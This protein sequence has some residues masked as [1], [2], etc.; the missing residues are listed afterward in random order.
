MGLLHTNIDTVTSKS[1]AS[2]GTPADNKT[3]MPLTVKDI[4]PLKGIVPQDRE[5]KIAVKVAKAQKEAEAARAKEAKAKQAEEA[6]AKEAEASKAKQAEAAKADKDARIKALEEQLKA[7]QAQAPSTTE[8][9][10]EF[11]SNAST[12]DSV[13]SD[14]GSDAEEVVYVQPK[15]TAAG[16]V[17]MVPKKAS[18]VTRISPITGKVLSATTGNT[19]VKYASPADKRLDE[20]RDRLEIIKS[21]MFKLLADPVDRRASMVLS[22]MLDL[23]KDTRLFKTNG[24]FNSQFLSNLIDEETKTVKLSKSFAESLRSTKSQTDLDVLLMIGM[25]V[26]LAN[27]KVASDELIE[28]TFMDVAKLSCEDLQQLVHVDFTDL[29]NS[30][31]ASTHACGEVLDEYYMIGLN[32]S[33][34]KTAVRNKKS[35]E[36]QKEK[37]AFLAAEKKKAAIEA[38]QK[39]AD[40]K[41]AAK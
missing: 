35:Q 31:D 32:A 6:K 2:S 1:I 34:E 28:A 38:A 40:I 19:G 25:Y 4:M 29:C 17:E 8:S 20:R 26:K 30:T 23:L 14:H 36:D 7:A 41:N 21:I 11:D 24:A 5:V 10:T 16:S 13:G 33:A 22:L 3:T 27:V 12:A 39:F 15:N 37:R 18:T 9:S